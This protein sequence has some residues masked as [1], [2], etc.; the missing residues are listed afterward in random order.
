M[1]NIV[2]FDFLKKKNYEEGVFCKFKP[3]F[4][5][6]VEEVVKFLLRNFIKK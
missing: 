2:L 1:K 3:I 6:F 5:K 4:I